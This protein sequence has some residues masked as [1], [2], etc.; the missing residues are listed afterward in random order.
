MLRPGHLR[1]GMPRAQLRIQLLLNH[2]PS[3][4]RGTAASP[5]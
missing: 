2:W 5:V 1:A 4:A 3:S